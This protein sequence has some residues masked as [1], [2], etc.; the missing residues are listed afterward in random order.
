MPIRCLLLCQLVQVV[1]CFLCRFFYVHALRPAPTRKGPIAD[2][3]VFLQLLTKLSIELS[4]S[5]QSCR[6][7]PIR[8]DI[9]PAVHEILYEADQATG[10][11][12]DA[13]HPNLAQRQH[14]ILRREHYIPSLP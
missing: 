6:G 7:T 2:F 9:H 10:E 13:S 12:I 11:H 4:A 3:T 8:N 14:H 1:Q 5:G